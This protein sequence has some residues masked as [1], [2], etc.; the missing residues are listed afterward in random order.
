MKTYHVKWEI[1]LDAESSYDA[2]RLALE[3][4]RDPR[5]MAT[6]FEVAQFTDDPMDYQETT[7]DLSEVP[8]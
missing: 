4:H 2:A 1:E 3:I 7:I 8:A 5:S 6:V